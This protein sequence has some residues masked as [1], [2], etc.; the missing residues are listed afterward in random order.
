MGRNAKLRQKRKA[1]GVKLLYG[2][3][4]AEYM[5]RELCPLHPQVNAFLLAEEFLSSEIQGEFSLCFLDYEDFWS[6]EVLEKLNTFEGCFRGASH[7]WASSLFFLDDDST[8]WVEVKSPKREPANG[9]RALF[10]LDDEINAMIA[11]SQWQSVARLHWNDIFNEAKTLI[12][13][14]KDADSFGF[15]VPSSRCM[16][17]ICSSNPKLF[18]RYKASTA[19][20]IQEK[21]FVLFYQGADLESGCITVNLDRDYSFLDDNKNPALSALASGSPIYE[22]INP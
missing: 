20:L 5:R 2:N 15:H 11:T 3:A 10:A 19:A 9:F 12:L 7:P 6:D 4:H 1:L 14:W 18:A 13:T 21:S 17:F 22:I 16:E 8:F